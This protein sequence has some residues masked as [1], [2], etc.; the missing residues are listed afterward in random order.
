[1]RP[2]YLGL[3]LLLSFVLT[4][5]SRI[6]PLPKEPPKPKEAPVQQVKAPEVKAAPKEEVDPKLPPK[7]KS[8]QLIRFRDLVS[9]RAWW[10]GLGIAYM[11]IESTGRPPQSIAD[12]KGQ[13]TPELLKL[14]EDGYVRFIYKI[15]PAQMSKGPSNTVIAY[16][17]H[18]DPAALR[19]VLLGDGSIKEVNNEEFKKLPKAGEK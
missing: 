19:L 8:S 5:C 1:M 18:E 17:V 6:A 16:E 11:N 3:C 9:L 7:I 15:G 13:V 10:H 12:F 2:I 4:G 14:M